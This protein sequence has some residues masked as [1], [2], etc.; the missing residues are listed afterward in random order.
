MKRTCVRLAV[1][2]CGVLVLLFSTDNTFSQ[3]QK[4]THPKVHSEGN[5]Y[6]QDS[7]LYA[8][9]IVVK[10]KDR[11]IDLPRGVRYTTKSNIR[12]DFP[13]LIEII[14]RFEQKFESLTIIKQIPNAQWGD[15]LRRHKVTGE[16]V[17]IHDLSQL[18]TLRFAKPVP[19]DSTI[20]EFLKLPEVEYAHEPVSIVYYEQPGDEKFGQQWNLTAV[21]AVAA[22]D[23][24]HGSS[25]VKIGI[26]DTGTD[27]DHEDLQSKIVGGDGVNGGPLDP[28]NHG[29]RLAGVAAAATDN[30]LGVASLGWNLRL[31]T[32]GSDYFTIG[33][34]SFTVQ[35]IN[36]AAENVDIINMSFGTL[37]FATAE[38]LG[39]SCSGWIDK[40]YIPED[41][42]SIRGAVNNAVTQGVICV[43]SAGNNSKNDD[44]GIPPQCNPMLVPYPNYPAQ[45]PDVI[46]V[47]GTKLVSSVEQFNDGWNYGSFVDVSAPGVNIWTTDFGGGY[48]STQGTSFSAPLVCALAGLI[49]SVNPSFTR[50]QVET[51]IT[52]TAD[53][54]DASRYP[55]DGNG[56]NSRLGYGR[57]NAYAAVLEAAKKSLDA[58]ASGHNSGRRLVRDSSGNY[59][60][61]FHSG[62]AAAQQEIFYRKIVSG[63]TWQS[64]N[65]L[66]SGNGNNKYPSITE[67]GGK[68]FVTWQCKNGSTHDIWFHRSD[69]GGITWPSGNRA[70][71]KTSVGSADPLPVI[72]SPTTNTLL[73][74]YRSSTS[75]QSRYSA[76]NG[77][78][79]Y[80][81][82]TWGQSGKTLSSPSL[83]LVKKT[84]GGNP[85]TPALVYA[86]TDRH[87]YYR[88]Y[89]AASGWLG[90]TQISGVVPGTTQTHQTPSLATEGGGG[91]VV[92]VAWH[93]TTGSGP[94]Q[95]NIIYRKSTAYNSWDS[96]Y[97]RIYYQD[98]RRPTITAF[99]SASVDILYQSN[100]ATQIFKQHYT[101][102]SWGAPTFIANGQYPSVSTGSTQAKY[103]WTSSGSAPYTINLS[104]GTLSK[105]GESGEPFYERAIS[106]LD[107]S[108]SHLTVRVKDISVKT[109]KGEWH[110]LSLEP[111]ALDTV[112]D[113]VPANAFDF[114]V[115]TPSLLPA[116]AESLAVNF[117]LWTENAEKVGGGLTPKISLEF[118]DKSEKSLSK[119]AG[120]DFTSIGNIPETAHR[121]AVPLNSVKSVLGKS[122]LKAVIKV[123]GLAP[124]PG[125]FASLGHIYDFNKSVEKNSLAQQSTDGAATSPDRFDLSQNY[126]NPFNPETVIK[127]QLTSPSVVS[128]K[129]YN[130]RG[131]E[132]RTLVNEIK[133]AGE[134]EVN[135]DGKDNFAESVASG[136]YVYRLQAGDDVAVKKLTLLR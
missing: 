33:N 82:I 106:W 126:P 9:A 113:F 1:F 37:R 63:T 66:S 125:V 72:V 15:V 133:T 5:F 101:G 80:P 114:L 119:I 87:V 100:S 4:I 132:V 123:E 44:L 84:I 92:Y 17:Q 124:K 59:H 95:N 46:A 112:A 54:I 116:D 103:I 104:S 67:R 42:S 62:G 22:W 61:V 32:Y 75:L 20:K 34:E 12:S 88:Y 89:D 18:F 8:D 128:L 35:D 60:L 7:M 91:T 118:K 56:W 43:A 19:L 94:T 71:V 97:T 6:E 64:A 117:T 48:V 111:V 73:V 135:W 74:V 41:Y 57:I 77:S 11:V 40:A 26:V 107:S 52:G 16:L 93:E 134:Y 30:D 121:F 58:D 25:T 127:Y 55:Y 78:S 136:V 24:T 98:Q 86:S 110:R 108:G 115:S 28:Q 47:S 10:F 14:N 85:D 76:D 31:F 120:P 29:T 65:Q 53:K 13:T 27:Q 109:S 99:S 3:M 90:H 68:V 69:D 38:D 96:Q 45:Y 23:I 70:T 122:E 102:S 2:S 83:A 39:G 105:E 131:Q 81:A 130:L 50:Q 79:W 51:I 129:I 49:K 36:D 21:N